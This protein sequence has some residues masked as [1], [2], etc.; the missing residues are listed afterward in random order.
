MCHTL[1]LFI[2]RP[3]DDRGPFL[4]HG[5]YPSS[6]TYPQANPLILVVRGSAWGEG[7][8]P[9]TTHQ[10]TRHVT[11]TRVVIVPLYLSYD[12]LFYR[13]TLLSFHFLPSNAG[14]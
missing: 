1:I 12:L 13:T 2:P 4:F 11:I 9:F 14:L 7:F 3:L 8:T 10:M 6:L 5:R